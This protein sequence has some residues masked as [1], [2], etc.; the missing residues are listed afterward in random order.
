MR[1]CHQE[2]HEFRNTS[3][4]RRLHPTRRSLTNSISKIPAMK[5]ACNRSVPGNYRLSRV[6]RRRRA[7]A[8][9]RMQQLL[10][11]NPTRRHNFPQSMCDAAFAARRSPKRSGFRVPR[12]RSRRSL[13]LRAAAAILLANAVR[14]IRTPRLE[15]FDPQTHRKR[16]QRRKRHA[17]AA[18]TP[19]A[20]PLPALYRLSRARAA[21]VD[22]RQSRE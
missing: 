16:P 9:D 13:E 21:N 14:E 20:M 2:R 15:C 12:A 3:E 5:R 18:M 1:D 17:A 7:D 4:R 22:A 11:A 6:R 19:A 8:S 10:S